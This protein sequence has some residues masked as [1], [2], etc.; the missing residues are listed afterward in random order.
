MDND[1]FNDLFS[2]IFLL[3][4]LDIQKQK[5]K[6][7]DLIL[8]TFTKVDSKHLY[9]DLNIKYKAIKLIGNHD[10]II[11][12]NISGTWDWERGS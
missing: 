2:N 9:I 8:T 5:K 3:K 1:L 6:N 11:G 10:N 12:K 4:Q 7:L